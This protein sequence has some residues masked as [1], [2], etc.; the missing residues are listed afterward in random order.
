MFLNQIHGKE[1]K[2]IRSVLCILLAV[3]SVAAFGIDFESGMETGSGLTAVLSSFQ[4][5][6][7]GQAVFTICLAVLY[8]AMWDR[9]PDFQK[10]TAFFAL[11]LSVLIVIGLCY[12]NATGI[13]LCVQNAVQTAKTAVVLIGYGTLF[14]FFVRWL[15]HFMKDFSSRW[16]LKQG[17]AINGYRW[18]T[19]LF[20]FICWLPYLIAFYPGT[21]LYDAGTM[22]RQYY[23]Y[24]ALTNHHPYF[25][26]I[27]LAVFIE[28]GRALGSASFG[29]FCYV[30][31][32]MAAFI[33]VLSY[34][35]DMLRRIGFHTKILRALICL[36]A[37]LPVF[38]V[39]AV[40]VG[41]NIN[42]SIVILLLT[43]FLFEA[44]LFPDEFVRSRPKMALLPIL[45]VLVCLFR[46]EGPAIAAGFFPCFLTAAKKHW[47][48]FTGIFAGV[49][50]FVAFWFRGILPMAGVAQGSI[51]ESL[52][53]PFLQTARCVAYYGEEMPEEEKAAIDRIL[54]FDTL[55]ERYLPEF[56]D[57]VKEK[58][59]E[60]AS[61]EDWE[62]YLE[63]Y[64][65]QFREHPVTCLDAVLNKCYGYFYPDDPGK[66]KAYYAVGAAIPLPVE[67]GF[68][69]ES[70]FPA[71]VEAMDR[72]MTAFRK[73][74]LI[75][76]TTSIGLYFWCCFLFLFFLI[77]CKKTKLLILYIPAVL[78]FLVCVASPVNAYFRYGLSVVFTVPFFFFTAL[79]AFKME[80][81]EL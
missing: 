60:N 8:H 74:P 70:R 5:W 22:L 6:G 41:K 17:G 31:L 69:L 61:K 39:Y 45:L 47:K 16:I 66:T 27:F 24:E 54:E 50:L 51:A 72:F 2:S 63:V 11:F 18:K 9:F 81:T 71:C 79:Y 20:L 80:E 1:K 77:K 57:R 75:G 52:S 29:M 33:M 37:F 68:D 23:G 55:P 53:V 25:Q 67:E 21:A 26:I 32:Q 64:W 78:V 34:M 42:F 4:G 56:S 10:D 7:M 35:A 19:S 36:Y 44:A 62:A 12:R 40:S 15:Y 30:L 3:C 59:N 13:V 38:P 73:I 28:A 14:Y 46:N 58:Y 49:A 65:K 43:V 76:Y 48:V